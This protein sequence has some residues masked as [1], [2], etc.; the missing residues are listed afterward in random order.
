MRREAALL[1]VLTLTLVLVGILMVYSISAIKAPSG[2]PFKSH[3]VYATLGLGA[4][5][6]I[7]HVDYHRLR[8]PGVYRPLVVASLVLLV[9]VLI[10]GIGINAYGAQRWLRLF[11]FQFQPSEFAK[12]ALI[13]LVAAKLTENRDH[14]QSLK[15]GFLPPVLVACCFA[16]LILLERDL[17]MPVVLMAVTFVMVFVAGACWRH[18]IVSVTMAVLVVAALSVTSPHRLERLRVYRNPWD[19]RDDEAFQLVQSL[20]AFARGGTYGLGPGASEQKL[21]YLPAAETD[22]IF[23]IWAEEMGLMGSLFLVGLYAVLLVVALR[24]ASCAR[25]LFGTLLAVGIASLIGL[26]AAFIMAVN[27]GLL[28]TKG[29]PLPFVSHGGTALVIFLMLMGILL[30]IARQAQE[31]ERG[32]PLAQ[33]L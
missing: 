25:D 26:Q 32:V 19:F 22:F 20:T 5:W 12:L 11:T 15:R 29:L 14:I 7:A 33:S 31:P 27:I 4:M 1:A 9:L 10:P 28:P 17:G 21:F 2:V 23:A 8:A 24:V 16:G 13:V 30:N 18:M 6:M 3:L